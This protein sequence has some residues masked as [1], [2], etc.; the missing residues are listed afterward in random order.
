M[1]L[2]LVCIF[3]AAC[4]EEAIEMTLQVP[5]D[6]EQWDTSCVQTI[7]VFTAGAN[8][9]DQSNDYIGQTLDL[10]DDPADSYAALKQAVRGKFEV[11]IPDS[12]LSAVE[13]YGWNGQ[14]GFFSPELFPELIFYSRV[15]YTGQDTIDIELVANLDCRLSPVI[16]RPIELMK[17][18][19]TKSCA[20][21]AVT[22]PMGFAS[23]GTLS[24]GL[25]KPYLFGWGGVHGAPV[26]NGLA[27][28][29]APLMAGPQSCL[30]VYGFTATSS[31]GGC[32]TPTKACATGTEIEAVLVEDAYAL[33]LDAGIQETLRGA[34]VGAVLDAT[35][36]GIAGATVAVDSG[37][38][39]YV[40]PDTATKR[41][42]PTGGTTTGASGMF[43][44]YSNDLAETS[45]TANGQT[46]T[47]TIGAQRTFSD[48]TKA[49]AG[50]V[51]TF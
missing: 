1:R 15:P 46:K 49:P 19:T 33:S 24:P 20:M 43:V 18:V 4:G 41:L 38:V 45:V 31:T 14:S 35:K 30:A 7:E 23:I 21:A 6:S 34:V 5:E 37:M 44:V 12:G 16:V 28:F 22:D 2:V 51:V 27:S 50:V 10:S 36:T 13:M 48:G 47:V 3:L 8:Y 25:Y 29:N 32:V 26:A 40:N 42:V 17:L 9:P 11:A 39:V